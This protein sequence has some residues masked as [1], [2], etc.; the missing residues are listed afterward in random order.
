MK[1]KFASFLTAVMVLTMTATT[2][3]AAESPNTKVDT[4]VAEG[5]TT[6]TTV[7][8][9]KSASAYAE[10]TKAESAKTDDGTEV[11]VEVTATTDT[12]VKSTANQVQNVLN[13]VKLLGTTLGD[14]TLT[15]AAADSTKTVTAE[16][17]TVVEV[18]TANQI[19]GKLTLTL[20]VDGVKAGDTIAVL[21]YNGTAWETIKPD[22]VEDGKVTFTVTSLSP[23][24]V[25]KLAVADKTAGTTTTTTNAT[26]P[27]TGESY[28]VLLILACVCLA[29]VVVCG[30]KVKF[31][32]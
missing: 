31:N 3:F 19:S 9:T 12:T 5:Q 10:S 24:A 15:A 7:A 30:K 4:T 6:T 11:A 1:K 20:A 21:H 13:N 2:V 27:K 17:K 29:G 25:V 28:P 26:S 14:D 32:K 23:I 16:I 8:E 22:K 18:D